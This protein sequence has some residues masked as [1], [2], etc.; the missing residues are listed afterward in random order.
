MSV[1]TATWEALTVCAL[2]AVRPPSAVPTAIAAASAATPAASTQRETLTCPPR[3]VVSPGRADP[4]PISDVSKEQRL[5][6][7]GVRVVLALVDEHPARLRALVAGDD[8]A[9]LEH[10]D[11]PARARV[12]DAQAPLQERDG[13]SLRLHDDLDRLVEER[14]VVRV[15][16]AVLRV[17]AGLGKDLREFQ[18]ALVELLL[19]LPRLLDDER[20]LFLRDVR[21]LHALQARGAERLEE[22]VAL[23]EQR[24]GASRVEDHARVGLRRDGECD[25]RRDVRLDHPGD[26]VD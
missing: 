25:A 16:L 15:E 14:V 19:A 10:V 5:V 7:G 13:R 20:D 21:A 1:T 9:S 4:S 8:P 18:I 12:A 23:A 11:Q 6:G 17:V 2:G 3:F 26:H 24:L 22:H